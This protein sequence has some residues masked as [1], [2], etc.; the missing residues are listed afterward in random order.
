MRIAGW[1]ARS[2]LATL[3]VYG[4]WMHCA[5]AMGDVAAE[6]LAVSAFKGDAAALSQL[7]ESA[8]RGDATA[9]DW[10]GA[11]R[12]RTDDPARAVF[13]YEKAA[14]QG[15]VTAQNNLGTLYANGFGAPKNLSQAAYW[16]RKAAEQG[17]ATAQNN[18][19]ILYHEGQGVAK[20][21][22]IAA[23]WLSKAANQGNAQA[24]LN[25]SEL[26]AQG[27]GRP[28][29]LVIAYA[30]YLLASTPAPSSEMHRDAPPTLEQAPGMSEQQVRAAQA[31]ERR[32]RAN[33]LLKTLAPEGAAAGAR[34]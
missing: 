20:N 30:L 28:R 12:Q 32:M 6:A 21:D 31:L 14:R 10:L 7:R 15:N 3:L 23:D 18:L 19:G 9:Q 26:Y 25:L 34:K 16:Y 4:A 24:Q 29:N 33:G 22:Q 2:V 5:D 13:W 8:N 17:N 27:E 11:Y 1:I